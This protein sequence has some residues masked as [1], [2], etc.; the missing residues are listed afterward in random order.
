MFRL[1]LFTAIFSASTVFAGLSIENERDRVIQEKS[2]ILAADLLSKNIKDKVGSDLIKFCAWLNSEHEG[3]KAIRAKLVFGDPVSS[4][5]KGD[6]THLAKLLMY[7]QKDFDEQSKR[8]LYTVIANKVDPDNVD[9][10]TQLKEFKDQGRD[11]SLS[12]AIKESEKP[13]LVDLTEVAKAQQEKDMKIEEENKQ[14]STES[15]G[16]IVATADSIEKMLDLI[17]FKTF[18][19]SEASLLDA[20]NRLTHKM[21]WRGV[22]FTLTGRRISIV[23]TQKAHNGAIYYVGPLYQPRTEEFT[24]KN[25]TLR[26]IL[27]HIGKNMDLDYKVRDGEVALMDTELSE[28]SEAGEDGVDANE[29][30]KIMKEYRIKDIQKYRG[31][32]FK[33]NGIVTG[34]GRGMDSRVIYL[35]LDGG[36]IQVYCKKIDLEQDV[37]K[38]LDTAVETWKKDGGLK[39]YRELLKK[40][41]D[42]GE[43]IERKDRT[44]PKLFITFKATCKGMEKGRLIFEM[45]EYIYVEGPEEYLLRKK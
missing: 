7:R 12:K 39:K 8:I 34:L 29:L 37:Y 6:G 10:T 15:A 41:K 9:A 14:L 4:V 30:Q 33:M 13:K 19:Y 35:A 24:V 32:S 2:Y 42:T 43:E 36:L 44:N 3:V 45:P 28:I 18:S 16:N 26:D 25:K 11:I 40:A 38:R 1:L 27:D 22:Q 20:I 5:G 31:K 21:Y 17:K 23:G